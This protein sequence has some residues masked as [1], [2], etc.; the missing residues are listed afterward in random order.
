M[1]LSPPINYKNELKNNDQFAYRIG[2][3]SKL[4][5]PHW[6]DIRVFEITIFRR[7]LTLQRE[8]PVRVMADLRYR[9]YTNPMNSQQ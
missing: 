1:S 9:S 7:V 8:L 4:P 5:Q 2:L 3:Q 6:L